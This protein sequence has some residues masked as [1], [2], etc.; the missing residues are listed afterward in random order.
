[1]AMTDTTN[2]PKQGGKIYALPSRQRQLSDAH[3]EHLRSSGLS[4]ESI[5]LN[6][7]YSE[8]DGGSIAS[9]LSWRSWPRGKGDVIVI[10]FSL[11]GQTEPF[12]ARVRPDKPRTNEKTGKVIKYEQPKDTPVAPYFPAR[13]RT[14]GW[15]EDTSKPL[16]LTE[17]EKKAALLDQLGYATIGATG[18]SCFHDAQ[19][20]NEHDEYKLH[21]LIAKHA[22]IAGRVC[23]VAFDSDAAENDQVMRAADVLAAM[24]RGAG[25]GDV[26]FVKIPAG[27][28]QKLGIDDYF[29]R[30]GE[31]ATR[32]LFDIAEPIQG[33]LG[34]SAHVLLSSF[35]ALKDLPVDATLR[36]PQGYDL[37][38]S[39]E[40][41]TRPDGDDA[42]K[43]VER[44]PV[45][46]ARLVTDLYS[47]H[48]QCELVFR[49]GTGWK[50]VLVARKAI[51]DSR[52]LVAELAPLG[53][54]VDSNTASDVVKWLRDFE[55]ANERRLPRATS[56]ARCG[57]H[58]VNGESVYA[59]GERVIGRE[60]REGEDIVVERGQD[61]ARLWRA[62]HAQGQYREHL[63][64]LR[65]AWAAS[66]V[67]A[68]AIASAL[69]APLLKVLD[70]PLFALHLAG[71]S[72]RGKST[73]LKIAASLYGDPRDEEWV[74][75]WNSTTVG[76]EVR[77]S[78]LCDLPL[79][80]DEAG[81]VD[82][83]ERE[84]AVYMLVNG[85]GRVRG[86]REGG[87]R[88]AHSWRTV[89]LSTGERLL[90][91]ESAATGAQ[92]RVL[93]LQVDGFGAL[94]AAEVDAL[95]R[96]CEEHAG[97]VGAEWL[98]ALVETDEAAWLEMRRVLRER[99][100]SYQA[101]AKP[102]SVRARQATFW[103]LLGQVEAVAH[104]VL[105]LGAEGGATVA[106]L[107]GGQD[108]TQVEVRS[109]CDRGIDVVREW[110]ARSPAAFPQ[111]TITPNGSKVPKNAGH[112][113]EV[114]GYIDEAT[115]EL[116]VLPLELRRILDA[117]GIGDSVAMRE[118]RSKGWI[119]CAEGM[120]T[121]DRRIGGKKVRVV[122]FR[123]DALG[124]DKPSEEWG[125]ADA[126]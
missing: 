117:A 55:A 70:A 56:V 80:I 94:G 67:C 7:F 126:S 62:I 35:R 91:E 63:E 42:P 51:A 88:E 79:C 17:G 98:E 31:A 8:R 41:W 71:D 116:L 107:F 93:Q 57:W 14:L 120:L 77:A 47:G 65:R 44:S 30:F 15:L 1:M 12:F 83:K 19:H 23:F 74:T 4:D 123:G 50:K 75:S 61:R 21:A 24:L 45:F 9:I 125:G 5:A 27:D 109:A 28:G 43:L 26:R 106:R 68:A 46:I 32:Q 114:S 2:A 69:A 89:V 124:L 49:R 84:R 73:M 39:G 25:A 97:C 81:V 118:W 13:T 20:R 59:L 54:P 52:T 92:V 119:S 40:L 29:V 86:A 82:A 105:G 122:A 101:R 95:R 38:K 6:G 90:A 58:R 22:T 115:S 64:G 3:R 37:S 76:H 121:I 78:M 66:P 108:D 100:K 85:V 112:L 10:P 96:A 102:G 60:H 87:L 110:I 113:R 72:S 18:V 48:E 99:V 36:L 11:P 53:A 34:S 16:V 111:L 104:D 103:A 33:S